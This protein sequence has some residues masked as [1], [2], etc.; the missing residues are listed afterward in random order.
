MNIEEK[1]Y[2]QE[3]E[4]EICRFE[5][6]IEELVVILIKSENHSDE[7]STELNTMLDEIYVI[8]FHCMRYY[9][10]A[11][12]DSYDKEAFEVHSHAYRVEVM[13][14]YCQMIDIDQKVKSRKI[15]HN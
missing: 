15:R 10:G 14:R 8:K 4:D 11:D 3:A 9:K 5:K 1:Q 6:R 12:Y 7:I 13:I 2:L